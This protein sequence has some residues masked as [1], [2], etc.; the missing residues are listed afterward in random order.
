GSELDRSQRSNSSSFDNASFGREVVVFTRNIDVRD[1]SVRQ[2]LSLQ[3][4][5][6]SRHLFETGFDVHA[7]R[8]GWGWTIGADTTRDRANGS[9]AG[10][11]GFGAG[12]PS[13]LRSTRDTA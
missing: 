6:G 3:A 8:T 2:E 1:V 4:G 12:I 7:L 13:L 11:A 9:G 5:A 10:P